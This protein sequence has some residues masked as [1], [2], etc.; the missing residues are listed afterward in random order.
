MK[1]SIILSADGSNTLKL[2]DFDECY[3]SSN[4]AYTEACHIYI[5]CGVEYLWN[6]I[7]EA[8]AI[9]SIL[10]KSI[11][12]YDI[13]LGTALNAMATIV[14]QEQMLAGGA[15]VPHILYNGIE[16]YPIAPEEALQLNFASHINESLE[17]VG[18]KNVISI[19]KLQYVYETIHRCNWEADVEITPY[20]TLHKHENDITTVEGKYFGGIMG[21]HHLS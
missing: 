21:K 13:G 12:V 16:K 11:A 7:L 20:F 2:A 5:K 8:N 3:H 9:S 18:A 1:H 17:A 14:W 6:K 15:E 4:G 10:T 19:E